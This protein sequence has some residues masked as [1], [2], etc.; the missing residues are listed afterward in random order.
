MI[1]VDPMMNRRE[2]G[3]AVRHGILRLPETVLRQPARVIVFRALIE[4]APC[5]GFRWEGKD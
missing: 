3:L 2:L 4:M 1:C 5:L